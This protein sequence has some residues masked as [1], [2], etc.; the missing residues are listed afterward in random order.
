MVTVSNPSLGPLSYLT[1]NVGLLIK[2]LDRLFVNG[3]AGANDYLKNPCRS[4]PQF[5]SVKISDLSR[6]LRWLFSIEER[7]LSLAATNLLDLDQVLILC[8]Q[9]DEL[10]A[11]LGELTTRSQSPPSIGD[12]WCELAVLF[13]DF[14]QKLAAHQ[15]Q[16]IELLAQL[17]KT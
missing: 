10:L 17:A 11:T 8:T 3:G 4:S 12:S 5:T 7:I 2:E 9:Q 6:A 13:E 16:K 1:E 15:I 14:C